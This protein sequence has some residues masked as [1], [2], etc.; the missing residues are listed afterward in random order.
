MR[1]P[2]IITI[3]NNYLVSKFDLEA[4]YYFALQLCVISG[5]VDDILTEFGN[6]CFTGLPEDWIKSVI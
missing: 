3:Y 4:G 5:L 2:T 1:K 6:I